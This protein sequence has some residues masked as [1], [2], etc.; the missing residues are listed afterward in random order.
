MQVN[1]H[2]IHKDSDSRLC[3]TQ[4]CVLLKQIHSQNS[5]VSEEDGSQVLKVS[6]MNAEFKIPAPRVCYPIAQ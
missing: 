5:V 4:A 3:I 2:F 1:L 6:T